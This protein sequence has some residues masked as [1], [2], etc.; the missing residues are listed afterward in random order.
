MRPRSP[1]SS[2]FGWHAPVGCPKGRGS[3][4]LG[5]FARSEVARHAIR[6]LWDA[7]TFL[8]KVLAWLPTGRVSS[9]PAGTLHP[10]PPPLKHQSPLLA[11]QELRGQVVL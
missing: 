8:E 2:D 1:M 6:G 11:H 5:D 9:I 10:T 7:L 3:F 4:S